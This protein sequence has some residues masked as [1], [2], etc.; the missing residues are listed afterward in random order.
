MAKIKVTLKVASTLDGKIATKTGHSQWITE[1]PA[2]AKGHELRNQHDAILVGVNTV[3][4]DNPRL[5]T[6]NVSN[7][8]SPIRIILDSKGRT[9]KDSFCL[10]NDGVPII[11]VTGCQSNLSQNN[12]FTNPNISVLKAPTLQPEI[13]WL[14]SELSQYNVTSILVEGGSRIHASFIKAKRADK[15]VLFLAPKIIGGSDA[16]SWCYD[17]E[18]IR[19]DQAP[20]L[21]IRSTELVGNDLMICADFRGSHE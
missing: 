20:H 14:L 16:L 4:A 9:P 1:G 3:L 18:T 17:L 7:G 6:R 8:R 2:R 15:L 12:P 13:N 5:T 11:I 10:Q 19:L 21:R